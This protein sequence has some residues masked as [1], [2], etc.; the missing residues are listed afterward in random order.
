MADTTTLNF[1]LVK[2]EVG[3]SSGT[4]GG[5]LNTGLDTID[6]LLGLP[7][8]VWSGPTV[9]AT[10]T[11]DVSVS[12][13]FAFTVSQITTIAFT[14]VPG[15]AVFVW[16]NIT[17]GGAFAVTWPGS[18]TWL[19][20]VA[21]N[22]KTSGVDVVELLT[23]DAGVTWYASLRRPTSGV[24]YQNQS[25]TT[26]SVSDV[27]IASF[28]VPAGTLGVNGS[29][30]RITVHAFALTQNG[31]LN[32]KFGAGTVRSVTVAAGT[33]CA[34]QIEIVRTGSAT[35]FVRGFEIN[36]ATPA[37]PNTATAETLSGAVL[38]DFR[39]SA[40]SGGTFRYDTIGVEYLGS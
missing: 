4:W 2:P 34:E 33:L 29:R 1:S 36:N 15:G 12:H 8:L 9:G 35:Q 22:L 31:T 17:N 27:S 5:K 19:S 18:V 25:L 10:T 21:P 38:L 28:S 11:C 6:G 14:N 40:V 24:I 20:G 7:R 16:L 26:T 37:I 32:I 3:A 23:R 39:G 30:L 13:V